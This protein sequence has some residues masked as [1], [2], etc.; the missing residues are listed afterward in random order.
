MLYPHG[1]LRWLRLKRAARTGRRIAYD[2]GVT[3]RARGEDCI[4]EV[5]FQQS[6]LPLHEPMAWAVT[7]C[8][9]FGI[10]ELSIEGNT[11]QFAHRLPILLSCAVVAANLR[12]EQP[13]QLAGSGG[14]VA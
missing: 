14:I 9:S 7:I 11:F 5:L 12:R 13:N 3:S 10:E 4:A 8:F 2:H 6:S 1:K